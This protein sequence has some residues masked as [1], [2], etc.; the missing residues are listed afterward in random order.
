MSTDAQIAH[1]KH[2][3]ATAATADCTG[4]AGL[5]PDTGAEGKGG[6]EELGLP[7]GAGSVTEAHWGGSHRRFLPEFHNS[8]F[9]ATAIVGWICWLAVSLALPIP[10]STLAVAQGVRERCEAVEVEHTW[11]QRKR[12]PGRSFALI[13]DEIR[14]NSIK[15][16]SVASC[17]L[18]LWLIL[19]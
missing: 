13:Q 19:Y 8:Y 12:M 1:A 11:G 3:V 7:G 6:P 18:L 14:C 5:S 9:N 4:A 2:S 10:L 17:P 16:Y 15:M